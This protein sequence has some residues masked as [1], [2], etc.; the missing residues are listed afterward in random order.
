[1]T[2]IKT[3]F[4]ETHVLERIMTFP[5]GLIGFEKLKKF[6]ILIK[7]GIEW[8]QS[9][10][11]EKIAFALE[12]IEDGDSEKYLIIKNSNEYVKNTY[13]EILS[14]IGMQKVKMLGT[15]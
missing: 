5:Q 11:D 3:K 15:I 1:M 10:D 2:T 7:N 9:L 14:G 12:K 4:D 13:I 8:L 6:T